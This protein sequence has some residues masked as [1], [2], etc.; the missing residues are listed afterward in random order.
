MS[1]IEVIKKRRVRIRERIK[2]KK[3]LRI[4]MQEGLQ[5]Q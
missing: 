5:E 2:R 1:I 3:R 4:R